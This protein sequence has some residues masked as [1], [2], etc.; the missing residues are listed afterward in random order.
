MH[1]SSFSPRAGLATAF[2]CFLHAAHVVAQPIP[3]PSIEELWLVDAATNVRVAR[4]NDYD[5]LPLA[6]LPATLNIEA[7]ANE[8][9]ESVRFAIDDVPGST[10]NAEPYALGGDAT[11]DFNPVPA[12]RQSGWIKITATPY[13][14]D[15]G[16]GAAG[17]P[18]KRTLYR[19]NTDFIVDSVADRSDDQPGDGICRTSVLFQVARQTS[20]A[21]LQRAKAATPVRGS[22][23]AQPSPAAQHPISVQ[24]VCTLRAA[25]EEAN[26]MPGRQTIALDGRNGKVYRLTKGELRVTDRLAI[27]GHDTP[28]IDAERHWRVMSV[29]GAPGQDPLVDLLDLDLANGYPQEFGERGG[30]LWISQATV[31]IVGGVIRGGEA[32]F[33]GGIYMQDQGHA[34]LTGVTV[35]DN[36][37]GNPES[38]GG[39]GQTQRGGGIFNLEGNLTVRQ[40]AIVDNI[41]VR[42]G[43]IS[44]YG[45]LVRIENS[46]ILDNEAVS[47]GGGLENRH[48]NDKKGRMHIAFSTVTGNRAAT[49]MADPPAQRIG[50]GIFNTGW[51]YVA[52]SVIA[53]NTEAFATGN[54]LSSPDCYSPT[55]YD[56]KSYRNVAVGVIN[57]NCLLGDYSSGNL[58]GIQSGTAL[59]PL[60]AKL[61]AR[62][63]SPIAHRTPLS[64]SPLLDA[65]GG[66]GAI[67]PCPSTDALDRPRPVGNA[68]DI[69]AIERQ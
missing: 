60:D 47:L 66:A 42:G 3:G 14:A 19:Q 57:G 9:T 31:Q 52:S 67:Y 62:S 38:F 64:N 2:C 63:N 30:V 36:K 23:L 51:A 49:S 11:G 4:L 21:P 29:N 16:M 46:S 25:I 68:C 13:S 56:F 69:G 20:P 12:L 24:R 1:R 15:N 43:G 7:V 34:S 65:G 44:N 50:G 33:G 28:T 5:A 27:Y 40:S 8:T 17:A 39:G 53:G 58:F 18:F 32:N 6:F 26:A 54:A 59:S 61:G 37:A 35:R 55:Q 45:G 10:E 22:G 48:N 41:A